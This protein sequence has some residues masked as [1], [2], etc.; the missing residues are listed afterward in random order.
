MNSENLDFDNCENELDWLAF[1][2]VADELDA[3]ARAK[4]EQRLAVDPAAC[5]AVAA[6]IE[7]SQL[8]FQAVETGMET[9]AIAVRPESRRSPAHSAHVWL[10]NPRLVFAASILLTL[11]AIGW[12]IRI[13]LSNNQIAGLP[14]DDLAITWVDSLTENDAPDASGDD[15]PDNR[16]PDAIN[17]TADEFTI[18]N[19]LDNDPLDN[20]S[21]AEDSDL[22]ELDVQDN[23]MLLALAEMEA[24]NQ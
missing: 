6:A 12:A 19:V 13:N 11:L 20:N 15:E 23:W 4:F 14:A 5:E 10:L 17:L 8:V 2:Y 18:G 24:T 16:L 3:E 7:T 22:V 9:K 1:C 21:I